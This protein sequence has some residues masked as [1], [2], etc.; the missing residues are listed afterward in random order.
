MSNK[1]ALT[2]GIALVVIIGVVLLIA[3]IGALGVKVLQVESHPLPIY[4]TTGIVTNTAVEKRFIKTVYFIPQ[5]T[6]QTPQK[7]TIVLTGHAGGNG[8]DRCA[9]L[10]GKNISL[11]YDPNWNIW[12]IKSNLPT[13]C[14]F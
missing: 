8:N 5:L 4:H 12:T 1:K 2:S 11:T 10:V 14:N 3:G 6:I 7:G 9:S 13:G